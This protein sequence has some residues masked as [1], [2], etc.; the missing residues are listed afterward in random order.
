MLQD[1][2]ILSIHDDL[3]SLVM[4]QNIVYF[5]SKLYTVRGLVRLN[6]SLVSGLPFKVAISDKTVQPH[7]TF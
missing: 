1:I 3:W 6:L 5:H 7:H 4:I 2:Q